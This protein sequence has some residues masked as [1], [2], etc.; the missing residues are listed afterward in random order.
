MVNMLF[1]A[2]GFALLVKGADYLIDGSIA[3]AR[4]FGVS[5]LFIG[6]T[7]VAFGTSA[8]ELAVS[9][10]AAIDGSGIAIGNVLGSNIAN[11]A[12]IL[13]AT[14]IIQPLRISASTTKKEMPF[15]ILSTVAAGMLLLGGKMGLNRFDGVVLLCFFAIFV[16]YLLSMAKSDRE[17]DVVV[18]KSFH[19]LEGKMPFAILATVGGLAGVLFGSDLVVNS[20]MNL[21]RSFGVSDTLIGVTLVAFGTSLPELVTSIAAGLKKRADLAI[22]N[23]IGSNIFNL[24]L[25]LGIAAVASPI[26]SDRDI[27]QDVIFALVSI[28]LLLLFTG[29]KRRKLG[30][31]GGMALLAFYFVY[32]WLSIVAG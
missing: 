30:R 6:L 18:E 25:V 2:I 9:V 8:P 10:K 5:E 12:L 16:D 17:L 29:L 13:G 15:V 21:A 32:I 14:A 7:I 31:I 28:V 4:R 27:T 1:L 11:V 20:G 3:I 19:H 23:I 24:L 22:G 26:Q